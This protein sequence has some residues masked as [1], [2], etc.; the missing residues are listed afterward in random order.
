MAGTV[1]I[2]G[3]NGT[4]ALAFVQALLTLHPQYALVATVRN[5]SPEADPNTA[6]L[7]RIVEK[8]PG[9][10]VQVERLDLGKLDDVR[11]F[12]DRLS[13]QIERGELSRISAIVCNASTWS[14]EAGQKFTSDGLEATF[15][16]A[17]LSHYLLVLKL[18]GS[19]DMSSGRIVMLGS[20]THY[21]EKPNP[22]SAF[23]P[24]FPADIEHL[25]KPPP[26]R[27]GEVHDRGFQR[28]GTAK[29]SNVTFMHDL[30]KRLEADPKLSKVTVTAMDPG[31][32][33][34]S[35]AQTE[36]KRSVRWIMAAINFCMP[37]LRYFTTAFRPAADSARDL[38]AVSVEPQ[39]HGKRDYYVG[40]KPEA[41]A[42]ISRDAA[43][44]ER[45]WTACWKW[46]GLSTEDT[47]LQN[48]AV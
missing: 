14:L 6:A 5:A 22:L 23:G 40:R 8:H 35:R 32:L 17:H 30:N 29:L 46:A 28:Y 44:Q 16:V 36:Q 26:D 15:Q 37:V 42:E 47:I 20:I 21:P 13:D 7:M 48:S 38:V 18:L 41:S 4:L 19:M 25:V 3:A 10:K 2:T 9:V 1:L 27:A 45:L 33:A 43:V 12:A 31:G 24:E 39:F 11:R 34:A